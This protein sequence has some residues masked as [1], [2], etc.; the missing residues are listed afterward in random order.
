MTI[1]GASMK[2]KELKISNYRN[3]ESKHLEFTHDITLIIGD[4]GLGKTN[5]LESI[6]MLSPGR[7]LRNCPPEDMC[8]YGASGWNIAARF[9]SNLGEASVK[10]S[11]SPE[12]RKKIEFNGSKISNHELSNITNMIWL[13]PQME[14]L[15]LGS[16]GD[17]R[18]FLDRMVFVSHRDHASKVSKY[19]KLQRE[20]IK[21]L[22]GP[23]QDDSWI[24]I[25]EKEMAELGMGIIH[26]RLDVIES[27][28]RNIED[29]ESAFPKA[30]I[31]L[32]G[33]IIELMKEA[34][35]MEAIKVEF[36]EHRQKDRFSGRTN[37]GAGKCDMLVFYESKNMP[38][39]ACSTGEQKALLISIITAQQLELENK[40]IFLLDEVFVHLDRARRQFLA[41]FLVKNGAQV[42]ITS[43][44]RELAELFDKVGIIELESEAQ[45]A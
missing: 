36:K 10:M 29:L 26:N 16:P 13:T 2:L 33:R 45:E 44:E 32:D 4:N 11:Y 19:E 8:R 37:F 3:L 12:S 31:E 20:R 6:S 38:A 28:N 7:G 35:P 21:I 40:P 41:E 1:F 5:L 34:E 22:E 30:K 43:T 14:G 39:R 9:D 42:I 23:S 15:F 25:I 27:I 17:R 24:S 18:R